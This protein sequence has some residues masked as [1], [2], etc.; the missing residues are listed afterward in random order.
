M[1]L[2]ME[3]TNM[4]IFCMIANGE[5]P[6]YKVYEDD[7]V[8]A[9]L[10]VNPTAYGHT[11]VIPKQHCDSFLDCPNDV[12]DHVFEVAQMIGN[13]LEKNLECDGIN[14]LSNVHEA[15]GQSVHH[16][17]V[18]LIPRYEG[19]DVIQVGF[20]SIGDVDLNKVLADINK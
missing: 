1:S 16:F 19:K 14:V 6:S 17:H 9:F 13:R 8:L 18:H 20:G 7:S 2:E 5:I 12:R 11:L 15:A 4:C 3:D 10:D